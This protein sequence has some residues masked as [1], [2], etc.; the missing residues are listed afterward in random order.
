VLGIWV[1]S[2]NFDAQWMQEILNAGRI[3]E[4]TLPQ[5]LGI[6]PWAVLSALSVLAIVGFVLG[7]HFEKRFSNIN[8]SDSLSEGTNSGF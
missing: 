2:F 1:F 5:L 8:Q 3:S 7:T 4:K 6:S